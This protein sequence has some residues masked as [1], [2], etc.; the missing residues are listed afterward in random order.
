[1]W[2]DIGCGEAH[3]TRL[4]AARGARLGAFDLAPAFLRQAVASERTHPAG[5]RYLRASVV[6]LPFRSAAF[7][8]AMASMSLVDMPGPT[9]VL[10]ET[11]RVLRPG[12]FFQF[13]I[14]HPCVVTP[15]L[16]WGRDAVGW[17]LA[18]QVG[19]YFDRLSDEIEE[20]MFGAAPPEIPERVRV[21]RVPR[22]D[23]TLAEWLNRPNE[24]GFR[25]ERAVEPC[26]SDEVARPHP[27]IAEER[28]LPNFLQLRWRKPSP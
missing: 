22:F 15:H 12:A 3:N 9:R 17:K 8:V 23:R 11:L 20:W 10:A 19:R 28:L 18:R 24:V 16:R 25:P 4:V 21:F 26:A 13:S 2:L 27:A 6:D 5:V 1:M 14:T 7:D